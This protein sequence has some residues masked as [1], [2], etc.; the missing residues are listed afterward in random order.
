MITF[1]D[2]I[3]YWLSFTAVIVSVYLFLVIRRTMMNPE[4]S[5]L[6]SALSIALTPVRYFK[7]GPYKYGSKITLSGALKY[8][9]KKAKLNDFGVTKEANFQEHYELIMNSK[10]Y[11]DQQLTNLGFI[12]AST[13][14]LPD[15]ISE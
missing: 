1:L 6:N 15:P 14:A 13:V 12:F 3:F 11:K 10:E 7:L 5:L 8:A 2:F 4:K 9:M